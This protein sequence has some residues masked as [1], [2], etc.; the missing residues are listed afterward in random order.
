MVVRSIFGGAGGATGRSMAWLMLV[1][2]Y[3]IGGVMMLA[4]SVLLIRQL[5]VARKQALANRPE[6]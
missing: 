2:P 5:F 6:S 4:G 1:A 3:P